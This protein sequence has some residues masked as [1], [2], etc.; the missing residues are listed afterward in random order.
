MDVYPLS[1][2]I[3]QRIHNNMYGI[4]LIWDDCAENKRFD[5]FYLNSFRGRS[6]VILL[7]NLRKY[8]DSPGCRANQYEY[9]L[10]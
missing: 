6:F 7:K 9:S 4:C 8:L 1:A 3:L 10:P 2:F 5:V